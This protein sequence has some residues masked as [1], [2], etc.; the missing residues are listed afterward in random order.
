M[1]L[2]VLKTAY[3]FNNNFHYHTQIDRRFVCKDIQTLE[4]EE[5]FQ[6]DRQTDSDE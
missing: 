6:T 5:K 3:H 2:S 4:P 1:S